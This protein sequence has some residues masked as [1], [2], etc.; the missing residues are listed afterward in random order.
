MIIYL[1]RHTTPLNAKGLCYGFADIDVDVNFETE[2]NSI[3]RKLP[4]NEFAVYSSP[5]MRCKK[6]ANYLFEKESIVFEDDLKE[7]NFGEWENKLW[8]DINYQESKYWMDDFVKALTPNGESYELLYNRVIKLF[9]MHKAKHL[10][11]FA[12]ITHGGVIRSVLSYINKTALENSFKEYRIDY[13]AV[14]KISIMNGNY[15]FEIL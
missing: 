5:L 10:Q 6:L 8:N 1:I 3:K 12:W 11:G 7:M 9:K 15:S 13:A 4:Q 2:A 14:V